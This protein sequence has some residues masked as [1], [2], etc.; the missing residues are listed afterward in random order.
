MCGEGLAMSYT[1]RSNL[2]VLGESK[3]I[4]LSTRV[5]MGGIS[6]ISVYSM[7][8]YTRYKKGVCVIQAT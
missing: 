7:P 1:E 4:V 2:S 6:K 3:C 5:G 8:I